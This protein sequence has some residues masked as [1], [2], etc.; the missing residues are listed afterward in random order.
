MFHKEV[1][2]FFFYS[3]EQFSS[4]ALH[5]ETPDSSDLRLEREEDAEWEKQLDW[6]RKTTA[7]QRKQDNTSAASQKRNRFVPVQPNM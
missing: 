2:F 7:G 6:Y 3:Q 4:A 1:V 5:G